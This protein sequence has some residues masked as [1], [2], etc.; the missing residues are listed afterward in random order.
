MMNV[1]QSSI[2]QVFGIWV[3]VSFLSGLLI[4]L[5]LKV[6][7]TIFSNQSSADKYQKS[8]AAVLFFFFLNMV[9]T[10]YVQEYALQ[11]ERQKVNI[12][13]LVK[14]A[15][16]FSAEASVLETNHDLFFSG[17]EG[18]ES[19]NS[20]SL[21]KYL[22]VFWM[23]GALVFTIKMMGGYFYTRSL[24]ISSQQTIPEN[25]S[26]F[27]IEELE[28][29]EIK[30]NVK[31]FESHRIYTAFTFGFLKPM[32]VLPIGFFTSIPTE[33]IEAVLLHELYHIKHKDYLV[34]IMTMSFE[35]IFFYHPV[36]WWLS[37]NIRRE[38]EN[39]CD[40]QV[41]QL[42]DKKVYAHALLNME[43]YRQSMSYAI[44]FSNKPSN[45]KMR[46]M[47]IFEQKPEKN[48]GL[49]PFLSL[50]V[51]VVFLMSFT[52]YKLEDPKPLSKSL[53]KKELKENEKDTQNLKKPNEDVLFK[54]ENSRLGV[55]LE[56]TQNT[57]IAKTD[58]TNVKLYL[59]EERQSLN[60]RLPFGENKMA[61]MFEINE[62]AS[63]HFFTRKYFD[64]HDREQW[65]K[66][67]E[68]RNTYVFDYATEFFTF[69]PAKNFDSKPD[70]IDKATIDVLTK[71]DTR[72]SK[73][74]AK[75]EQ[76]V[77]DLSEIDIPK[78]D[79]LVFKDQKRQ[80][81]DTSSLELLK[82]LLQKFEA[83]GNSD[84]KVKIDGK[85]LEKN[86][87]I[88]NALGVRQIDNIK[89]VMPSKNAKP[90]EI[91]IITNEIVGAQ[92][93]EVLKESE[94][95]V[96]DIRYETNEG[97]FSGQMEMN[98]EK[99]DVLDVLNFT[100]ESILFVIAGEVKELGYRPK[101]IEP[102]SI[103]HIVVLKDKKAIGKYGDI[104][105]NGVIE[106]YLK[107]E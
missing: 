70:Q 100:N 39:R 89:I 4:F 23:I 25:W 14:T 104:A 38:R 59:D 16:D 93:G 86:I 34:N 1:L 2:I 78:P 42:A 48:I 52:F 33:Q 97:D 68:Y 32:I 74:I 58:N 49:K 77:A 73:I 60:E 80:A 88:E 61:T 22:G 5:I 6:F 18:S 50:L 94:S 103:D 17:P 81:Q 106:I 43:S 8:I 56:M 31:V 72:R 63:Y 26:H 29:L 92:V 35:I 84:V 46:I 36:M 65:T 30:C 76:K 51:I 85:L 99:E 107:Q 82:N 15:D 41:T 62:G 19:F 7:D 98:F 44:P 53:E 101:D 10:F 69:K 64:T 37:K 95:I 96:I 55:V 71:D 87:S 47:R 21:L 11:E 54:S 3:A 83:K 75:T 45:L 20:G 67:N 13:E 24:I 102:N 40:D 27:I 105:K 66:E 9:G 28:K 91:D 79:K 90:A 57:L 12:E